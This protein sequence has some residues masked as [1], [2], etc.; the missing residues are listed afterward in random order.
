MTGSFEVPLPGATGVQVRHADVPTARFPGLWQ[1]GVIDG[2]QYWLYADLSAT[3]APGNSADDWRI[4][5]TCDATTETCDR[6]IS[7]ATPDTARLTADMLERCLAGLPLVVEEVQARAPAAVPVSEADAAARGDEVPEETPA[8]TSSTL[9]PIA[10][11][12]P[13]TGDPSIGNATTASPSEASAVQATDQL[14]AAPAASGWPPE[15]SRNAQLGPAIMPPAPCGR[16]G[17]PVAPT[18]LTL[19]RLLLVAG[20]NPGPLDGF[21]GPRTRRALAAVLGRS[22]AR[23]DAEDAL[24]ALEQHLCRN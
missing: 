15:A 19:Q 23:L 22:A 4:E 7:G 18:V 11:A 13:A 8:A 1:Q 3:L 5:L 12:T 10:D 9:N 6:V 20:Q 2:L 16:A 17:L 24:Q 21:M 14:Q